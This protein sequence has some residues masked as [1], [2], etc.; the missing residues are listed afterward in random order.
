MSIWEE[1]KEE[2][3]YVLQEILCENDH[4]VIKAFLIYHLKAINLFLLGHL[5][6]LFKTNLTILN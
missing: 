6:T 1:A 3:K 4:Y 5:F 2:K